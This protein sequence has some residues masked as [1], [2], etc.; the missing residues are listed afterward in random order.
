MIF[1]PHTVL[2]LR[3]CAVWLPDRVIL[4]HWSQ[5]IEV[6][7]ASTVLPFDRVKVQCILPSLAYSFIFFFFADQIGLMNPLN[8]RA[9]R[10][11]AIFPLAGTE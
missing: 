6:W 7:S 9:G 5:Q 4:Q 1:T 11:N 8:L 10:T 3:V 2:N